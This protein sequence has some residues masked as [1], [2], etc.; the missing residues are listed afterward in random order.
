[1]TAMGADRFGNAGDGGARL[2]AGLRGRAGPLPEDGGPPPTPLVFAS[3]H[4]GR[5]YPPDMMAAARLDADDLRGS[6]D[7]FV[8][9]LI[10]G[11]PPWESA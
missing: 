11:A 4:S 1:M 5:L 8:D 7:A 6:E 9:D 10:A 2:L 3:P